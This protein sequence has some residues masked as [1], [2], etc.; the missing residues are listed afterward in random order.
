[1][2]YYNKEI[3]DK[4]IEINK[5]KSNVLNLKI[6]FRNASSYEEM[7]ERDIYDWSAKDA[8][9]FYKTLGTSS[10]ERL[11]NY[12][13]FYKRYCNWCIQNDLV[14][15]HQNS[16][17]LINN[18]I[19][20]TCINKRDF[21]GKSISEDELKKMINI[22]PNP[23]DQF[24]IQALY[25]GIDGEAMSDIIKMKLSDIDEESKTVKLNSGRTVLI[26]DKLINLA[27]NSESEYEYVSLIGKERITKFENISDAIIK[28]KINSNGNIKL[29]S[30][31]KNIIS[32]CGLYKGITAK[33]I[34]RSG[35]RNMIQKRSKELGIGIREYI[36]KYNDEIYQQYDHKIKDISN[37]IEKYFS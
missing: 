15:N 30:R 28:P 10:L 16:F 18:E 19:L 12:N 36:S 1:M 37:Y 2:C 29:Y 4:Y 23:S 21:K 5:N 7:L 9:N 25:E 20:M 3:K 13:S 6:A 34:V 24:I 17:L 26:S 33:S 22:I 31:V 8:V 35:E 32:F 11:S 27:K 14:Q